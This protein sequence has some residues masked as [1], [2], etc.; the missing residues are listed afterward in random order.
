[1]LLNFEI[2]TELTSTGVSQ[3]ALS[4]SSDSSNIMLRLFQ[5]CST[6]DNVDMGRLSLLLA[7]SYDEI[8]TNTSEI[9]GGLKSKKKLSSL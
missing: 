9:L 6:V 7:R 5:V 1:M 4:V 3:L 2:E 8:F